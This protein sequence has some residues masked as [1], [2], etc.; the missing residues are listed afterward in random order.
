MYQSTAQT[1]KSSSQTQ[2]SLAQVRQSM[3]QLR[4]STEQM[5]PST[6]KPRQSRELLHQSTAQQHL[7]TSPT[8]TDTGP[9]STPQKQRRHRRSFRPRLRDVKSVSSCQLSERKGRKHHARGLLRGYYF[10]VPNGRPFHSQSKGL[11]I[12]AY[13]NGTIQLAI[14]MV[15]CHQLSM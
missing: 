15:P 7:S 3:A 14:T 9:R 11:R 4:Q 6:R 13:R 8:R 10:L 1:Q 5:H 12:T 2:K